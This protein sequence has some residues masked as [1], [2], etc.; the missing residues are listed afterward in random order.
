MSDQIKR[1]LSNIEGM[2]INELLT[3][4]KLVDRQFERAYLNRNINDQLILNEL[5]NNISR[6]IVEE[7]DMAIALLKTVCEDESK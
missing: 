7:V 3:R 4:L 6:K 5:Q 1:E 2:T